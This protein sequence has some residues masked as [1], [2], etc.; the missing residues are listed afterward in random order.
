MVFLRR[1]SVRR[2]SHRWLRHMQDERDEDLERLAV[3][4]QQSAVTEE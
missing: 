3:S 4:Y 2:C 1:N